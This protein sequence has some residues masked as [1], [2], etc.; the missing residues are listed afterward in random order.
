[1]HGITDNA[2]VHAVGKPLEQGAELGGR[3]LERAVGGELLVGILS[4]TGNGASVRS[5]LL[6]VVKEPADRL[7][8][9]FVLL[10]LNDDLIIRASKTASDPE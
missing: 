8:V 4:M 5:I 9:V 2:E 1:M 3:L 10:A 6:D 7:L